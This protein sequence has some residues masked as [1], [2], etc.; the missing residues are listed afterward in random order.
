[1]SMKSSAPRKPICRSAKARTSR[2]SA[3]PLWAKRKVTHSHLKRQKV[4]RNTKSSRLI[5]KK[6]RMFER[7]HASRAFLYKTCHPYSCGRIIKDDMLEFEK[8]FQSGLVFNV[9][10]YSIKNVGRKI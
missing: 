9:L 3:L 1:M 4:C 5:S 7:D 8:F 10:K 2:R 6:L